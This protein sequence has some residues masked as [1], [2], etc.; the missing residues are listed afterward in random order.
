MNP[1]RLWQRIQQGHINN[2]DFDDF[3]RLIKAS[4]FEFDRQRGTS[5][6][7]FRHPQVRQRL[8]LQPGRDGSAKAYQV[9]EFTRY[10]GEHSLTMEIEESK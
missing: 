8:N 1:T 7:L 9:R 2:I 4:G 6:R 3:V 5:H 10:V